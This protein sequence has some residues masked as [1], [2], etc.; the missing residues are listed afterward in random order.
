MNDVA[1]PLSRRVH[2]ARCCR[3]LKWH[4]VPF[5]ASQHPR[6]QGPYRARIF[7]KLSGPH[8]RQS[9]EIRDSSLPQ[10]LNWRLCLLDVLEFG[11]SF[12][13]LGVNGVLRAAPSAT[14]TL[15]WACSLTAPNI[16]SRAEHFH[17]STA[18]ALLQ[19]RLTLSRVTPPRKGDCHAD[20]HFAQRLHKMAVIHCSPYHVQIPCHIVH[21]LVPRAAEI[22]QK[23]PRKRELPRMLPARNTNAAF[24]RRWRKFSE[25]NRG[26]RCWRGWS[27]MRSYLHPRPPRNPRFVRDFRTLIAAGPRRVSSVFHPWLPR[28][29]R[30]C[31]PASSGRGTD[32][33][34]HMVAR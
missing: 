26:F 28:C 6:L 19:G 34:C 14:P 4:P 11:P 29:P 10:A 18:I 30:R 8:S 24:L 31:Q 9:R 16:S 22:R 7:Q 20:C 13:H 3:A 2:A 15:A 25:G 12:G 33:A 32:K 23:P 21:Y 5:A 17:P 27:N 1:Y